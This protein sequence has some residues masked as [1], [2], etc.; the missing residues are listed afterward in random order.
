[1]EPV[2]NITINIDKYDSPEE[3]KLIKDIHSVSFTNV[4]VENVDAA[5]SYLKGDY[6]FPLLKIKTC[7]APQ[8]IKHL[9]KLISWVK[10]HQINWNPVKQIQTRIITETPQTSEDGRIWYSAIICKNEYVKKLLTEKGLTARCNTKLKELVFH[11]L[12][13]M[14]GTKFF[15]LNIKIKQIH[16]KNYWC[17]C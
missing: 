8:A 13:M 16:L 17:L 1:M 10:F 5:I 11:S 2:D 3:A 4:T 6:R 12:K 14:T 15:N 7:V 9:R